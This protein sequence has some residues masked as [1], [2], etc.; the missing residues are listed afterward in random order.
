M[1]SQKFNSTPIENLPVEE[2]QIAEMLGGLNRAE[3]PGDFEFRLKARIARRNAAAEQRPFM[4]LML[5]VA[6]P[7][8]LLVALGSFL[9][10]SGILSPNA[11]TPTAPPTAPG[12][13]SEAAIPEN[14]ELADAE[15]RSMGR[16]SSS[17]VNQEALKLRDASS[18]Q[19]RRGGSRVEARRQVEVIQP[20]PGVVVPEIPSSVRPGNTQ[21]AYGIGM[22]DVFKLIGVEAKAGDTGWE[23][24]SIEPASTAT[25]SGVKVGDLVEAVDDR[26]VNATTVIDGGF[27]AK[28]LKILRD[29]KR[30]SVKLTNK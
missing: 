11:P 26:Q 8:G 29:G 18:T 3:A 14:T 17:R 1:S 2:R 22:K 21:S 24:L 28:T 15:P 5:K 12:P 10:F 6:A 4:L 23:I 13:F 27:T 20:P 16:V 25:K 7:T 30:I 9:T 19:G